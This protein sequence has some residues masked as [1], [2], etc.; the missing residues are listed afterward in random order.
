MARI[1]TK[2]IEQ[3]ARS[4]RV[5]CGLEQ[6][7]LAAALGVKQQRISWLELGR[8]KTPDLDLLMKIATDLEADFL[9]LL[10]DEGINDEVLKLVQT[11]YSMPEDKQ[12]LVRQM[13]AHLNDG[14]P[15]THAEG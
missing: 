12:T 2:E 15:D 1:D 14:P 4:A 3:R 6:K 7:D 11:I 5:A 9:E 8:A 13:I 10:L